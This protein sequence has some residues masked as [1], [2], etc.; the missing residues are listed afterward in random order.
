M[1]KI[2]KL[3]IASMATATFVFSASICASAAQIDSL[4][5]VDNTIYASVSAESARLYVAEYDEALL[6]D[7]FFADISEDGNVELTI[8]EASDYKL[9]LW[10]KDSL[11][12]V[13]VPYNLV[14]GRAYLEGSTTPVPEYEFSDYAFD[15]EDDVM[16][17]SSVS[18]AEI[19][20]FK[21][22]VETSYALTGNVTVLGLSDAFSDVVPGSVVLIG[23]NK[24]GNCSAIELLASMGIP[25]DPAN[26][27]D[28]FGFY[29]ASDGSEKYQNFV[30]EMYSKSGPKM[31]IFSLDEGGNRLEDE[32]G[33]VLTTQYQFASSGILCYRVGIAMD[34]DTPIISISSSKVSATQ[35]TTP[36]SVFEG[37]HTHHNYVYLRYNTEKERIT[38]CVVYCV[39]KDF[40]PGKGDGDY[41]DIFSVE[42]I[43]IIE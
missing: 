3:L 33:K 27:T 16:I 13:S 15:L 22:G 12:P 17:V 2:K 42:P 10:D 26:F 18:E 29:K 32:D 25:V 4:S 11:A 38:Q 31:S 1:L 28:D 41:S 43:V 30:N 37:T 40:N 39:P 14:E 9:F 35:Y 6:S 24:A 8:G 19:K 20:G 5:V 21:A 23:T 36:P 7:A 34:G